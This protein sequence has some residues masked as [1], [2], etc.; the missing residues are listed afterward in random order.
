VGAEIVAGT[1]EVGGDPD[2]IYAYDPVLM[3]DRGAILLRPGSWTAA[4]TRAAGRD[5]AAAGIPIVAELEEPAT[6]EG[7]T[8]SG[9]INGRS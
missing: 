8:C 6:A 2:A 4:R 5:L 1:S 9:S 3:T 7:A